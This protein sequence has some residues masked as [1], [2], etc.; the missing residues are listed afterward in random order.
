[1]E[2]A[3]P[4]MCEK[5]IPITAPCAGTIDASHILTAFGEGAEGV[6]VAGCH[7]GNCASIF[8][9]IL[10]GERA[11]EARVMLEEAGIN[12]G[13]RHWRGAELYLR[14][15]SLNRFGVDCKTHVFV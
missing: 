14:L 3:G 7:T 10:A 6:L 4:A 8:G 5:L 12:P 13:R 9:N 2:A 1:M 11:S 15:W